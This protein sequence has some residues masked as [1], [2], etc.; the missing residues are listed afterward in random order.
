M[1]ATLWVASHISD[2]AAGAFG[3][4]QQVLETLFVLFR[5][6]ALGVGVT[7][8]QSLGGQRADAARS[9]ALVGLA[10]PPG[11]AWSP[12]WGC[13]WATAGRSTC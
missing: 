1:M 10:A 13:W 3:M 7:I 6:L 11:P 5:V 2:A 9:I 12:R 8:T 4:S